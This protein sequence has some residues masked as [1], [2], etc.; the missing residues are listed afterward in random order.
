MKKVLKCVYCRTPQTN[1]Q[2]VRS[3][4][5]SGCVSK[6]AGSPVAI[7]KV[8]KGVAPKVKRVKGSKTV[9]PSKGWG[10]GWHLKKVFVAPDGS[11]Y[12]FG[13]LKTKGQ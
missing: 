10:R 8:P 2:G 3:I 13:Q 9:A 4:L 6:L 5:C 7:G 1:T 12:E 11:R